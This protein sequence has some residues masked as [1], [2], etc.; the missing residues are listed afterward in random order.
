[1]NYSGSNTNLIQSE[2]FVSAPIPSPTNPNN[3]ET[4][5]IAQV[6]HHLQLQTNHLMLLGILQLKLIQELTQLIILKLILL[7][8]L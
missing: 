3:E 4:S 2:N 5:I 6:N 1:M 8:V 7:L